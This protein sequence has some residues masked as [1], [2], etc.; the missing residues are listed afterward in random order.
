MAILITGATGNIG[1]AVVQHLAQHQMP[2]RALVRDRQKASHLEAQGIELAQGDFSQP[3][4]LEKALQGIEKAFLAL[5]PSEVAF[6]KL[7]MS[8]FVGSYLNAT[9]RDARIEAIAVV[10]AVLE[11]GIEPTIRNA[12]DLGY[13][14]VLISD[15]CYS[16]SEQNRSR[17]L[18]NLQS[19]S[20]I[21]DINTFKTTLNQV[22]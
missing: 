7:T 6:D 14:P 8:A 19:A 4:S 10:G 5:L 3:A 17:S 11:F 18:A 15:A 9:L 16:F 22:L 20:L 2:L 21:T 13:S 1:G 12:A